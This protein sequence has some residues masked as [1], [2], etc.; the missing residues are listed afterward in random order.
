MSKRFKF[1]KLINTP[2]KN[3][4]SCPSNCNFFLLPSPSSYEMTSGDETTVTSIVFEAKLLFSN[5]FHII[6]QVSSVESM[7]KW[8]K[9]NLDSKVLHHGCDCKKEKVYTVS[10]FHIHKRCQCCPTYSPLLHW[11]AQIANL[12]VHFMHQEVTLEYET[13][14]SPI[15]KAL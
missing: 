3:V 8:I 11:S 4:I 15:F 7:H 10:P 1:D 14:E 12:K 2:S 13:K 9:K 6:Y 5:H